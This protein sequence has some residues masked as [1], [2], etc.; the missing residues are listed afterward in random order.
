MTRSQSDLQPFLSAH[1]WLAEL[2]EDTLRR[3]SA[4]E[5][6]DPNEPTIDAHRRDLE[7]KLDAHVIAYRREAAGLSDALAAVVEP[8]TLSDDQLSHLKSVEARVGACIFVAFSRPVKA[9]P[10]PPSR[11]RR[12]RRKPS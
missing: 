11:A 12:G 1:P 8:A 7:A 10:R 5:W 9:R 3:L 6:V 2:G 4:A